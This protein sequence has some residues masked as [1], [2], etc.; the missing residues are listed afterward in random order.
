M[1]DSIS[2][3]EQVTQ[4]TIV[5]E[6][7]V[8]YEIG[9]PGPRGPAGIDLTYVHDQLVASA[10]WTIHHQLNKY[11]SITVVDSGGN[12]IEGD[13]TYTDINTAV[14]RFSVAFGGQAFCN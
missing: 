9:V 12:L 10:T 4:I 13:I 8:V 6:A 7:T 3:T 11:P 14:V 2:I 1:S 5:E